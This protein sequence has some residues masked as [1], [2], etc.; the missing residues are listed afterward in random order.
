MWEDGGVPP[1]LLS[2]SGPQEEKGKGGGDDRGGRRGRAAGSVGAEMGRQPGG[3]PKHERS[4]KGSVPKAVR[5][6]PPRGPRAPLGGR[7]ALEKRNPGL[8]IPQPTPLYGVS[9]GAG[10]SVAPAYQT[11]RMLSVPPV[12]AF[13]VLS[14]M[15]QHRTSPWW[16]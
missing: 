11:L 4:P 13:C 10:L 7:L 6:G 1:C 15:A 8:A 12:T 2:C 16:P 9:T 5:G 14:S 3:A